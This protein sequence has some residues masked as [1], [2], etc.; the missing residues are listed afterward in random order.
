MTFRRSLGLLLVCLLGSCGRASG[1]SDCEAGIR[2]RLAEALQVD[3]DELPEVTRDYSPGVF[4]G[5][6]FYRAQSETGF[7]TKVRVVSLALIDG[8]SILV[9]DLADLA[10]VWQLAFAGTPPQPAIASSAVRELLFQTGLLQR[11][12]KVISSASEISD[13]YRVFLAPGS[14]LSAIRALEHAMSDSGIR[15]SFFAQT[16]EG[17]VLYTAAI[18][19]NGKLD[20]SREV[21]ARLQM[22]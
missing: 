21:V 2:E 15:I 3:A 19:P 17:I 1:Q 22:S 4:P 7:H 6:V 11:S 9:Q 10:P 18:P 13:S 16:S 12:D 5:V 14:D 8:D 20:V